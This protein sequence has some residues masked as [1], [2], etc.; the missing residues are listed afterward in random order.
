MEEELLKKIR[1]IE[2]EILE[3]IVRICDKYNLEYVLTAGT[4]IGAK[5]HKGFIPWDDDIDIAFARKDFDKFIEVCK[6]ELDKTRFFLDCPDTND[7]YWLPLFKIR[8]LNTVYEEPYQEKYE[9]CKGIWVDILPLDNLNSNTSKLLKIKAKIVNEL[10]YII[11]KK[12]QA[13]RKRRKVTDWKVLISYIYVLPLSLLPIRV[14]EK[15]QQSIMKSNKNHNSPYI[16]NLA[17]KYGYKKQVFP[18]EKYFPASKIEF[19]GKEYNAPNDVDYVLT[20]IYG[21]DYMKLP[22]KEKQVTHFPQRIK[23]EGEEEIIFNK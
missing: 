1:V 15:I 13:T 16:V 6:I 19:E 21:E 5:R 2:I 7:K 23:F 10:R 9:K 4:L 11:T 12:A 3:E 20:K 14:L 22:P 18:R 17:S 8:K